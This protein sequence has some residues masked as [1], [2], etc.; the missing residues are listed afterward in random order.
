MYVRH[1]ND[2][3]FLYIL[4]KIVKEV[5]SKKK[6]NVNKL[7]I[8]LKQGGVREGA[9]MKNSLAYCTKW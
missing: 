8:M 5:K 9:K 1:R 2:K 3:T 4:Y 6:Q 7:L